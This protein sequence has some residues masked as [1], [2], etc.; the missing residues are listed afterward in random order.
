[1]IR[2]AGCW[3]SAG[4][5]CVSCSLESLIKLCTWRSPDLCIGKLKWFPWCRF[6]VNMKFKLK[7]CRWWD[8]QRGLVRSFLARLY[9]KRVCVSKVKYKTKTKI[10]YS[11]KFSRIHRVDIDFGRT[12]CTSITKGH[13]FIKSVTLWPAHQFFLSNKTLTKSWIQDFKTLKTLVSTTH[14]NFHL[15]YHV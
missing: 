2:G 9:I 13:V 3:T 4:D 7:L 8:W 11:T 10:N 1:M 5:K 12:Y 15:K 6:T 14:L